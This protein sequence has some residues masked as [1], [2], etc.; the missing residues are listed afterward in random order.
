VANVSQLEENGI[1]REGCTV[2]KREDR[3]KSELATGRLM[4]ILIAGFGTAFRIRGE[5]EHCLGREP[6]AGAE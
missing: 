6:G 3:R 5:E 4:G 1:Q 2:G